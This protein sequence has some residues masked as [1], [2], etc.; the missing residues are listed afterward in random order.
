MF[1]FYLFGL[2]WIIA[3]I[4]CVQQFMIACLACMWYYSGQGE[5]MS[6]ARG[7]VSVCTAFKWAIWYHVGSIA[8]GSFLIALITFIRIVFEYIITNTRRLATKRTP[9]TKPSSVLLDAS[10][11]AWI[12]TLSSLP[13]TP[14]FKLH[15]TLRTS[16]SLHGTHSAS[17]LDTPEDLDQQV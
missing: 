13:R 6:D 7:E 4:I 3:F 10:C 17:L 16:A 5:E 8:M 9:F 1:W 11:G 15:F 2:L 14:I 12:N